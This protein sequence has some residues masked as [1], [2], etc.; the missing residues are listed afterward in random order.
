M[1]L[2][3]IFLLSLAFLFSFASCSY[4]GD[5][6]NGLKNLTNIFKSSGLFGNS[7]PGIETWVNPSFK[8]RSLK[9]I[10]VFATTA[11]LNAGGSNSLAPSEENQNK[12][13]VA[14][15]TAKSFQIS[16]KKNK[17]VITTMQ[18]YLRKIANTRGTNNS[19]EDVLFFA[20]Q[21]GYQVIII[22]EINQNFEL[23]HVPETT[24]TYTVYKDVQTYDNKGNLTGTIKIPEEKTEIVPAHD[25]RYL[26][27]RCF[28][29]IFDIKDPYK[30]HL[31]A[32]QSSIY[33]EYQGGPVL[34][35][36]EN[37]IRASVKKLFGKK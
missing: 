12:Y 9:K 24:R 33:R 6:S 37:L 27:T 3:K 25:V 16:L 21:E 32:V 13:S 2:R 30:S 8:I 15:W 11:N 10:L 18:D 26:S 5:T 22:P 36:V 14:D 31:A 4:A 7:K 1:K 34:K 29:R 35:V 28:I 19:L 20:H 23:E 17:P